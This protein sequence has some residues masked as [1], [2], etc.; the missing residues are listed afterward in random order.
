[1]MGLS[2]KTIHS[3][4][5]Y[6]LIS[7]LL[8]TIVIGCG[9]QTNNQSSTKMKLDTKYVQNNKDLLD[10]RT[11]ESMYFTSA[12]SGWINTRSN[13]QWELFHT[14][15]AGSSWIKYG[16]LHVKYMK[17]I[18]SEG[19]MLS[20]TSIYTTTDNWNHTTKWKLPATVDRSSD[21]SFINNHTGWFISS[22]PDKGDIHQ[23]HQYRIY[24]TNDGGQRFHSS[25]LATKCPVTGIT[26]TENKG[27]LTGLCNMSG[28]MLFKVT[29]DG[30]ESWKDQ[31][32]SLSAKDEDLY[33]ETPQFVSNDVGFILLR[34]G[35]TLMTFKTTDGGT[36]WN[37]Q[38]GFKANIPSSWGFTDADFGWITYK[39]NLWT[40]DDG[41]IHWN[42]ETTLPSNEQFKSIHFVNDSKGWASVHDNSAPVDLKLHMQLHGTNL[43]NTNDSGHSWNKLY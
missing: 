27:W 29:N 36:K 10:K 14:N 30:G 20:D 42:L 2:N 18:G 3:G 40:T 13:N 15:D 7:F 43:Y 39:S 37:L 24:Q 4:V 31:Y 1:M 25:L 26:F 41:G 19:V 9:R 34:Q 5:I 6:I 28:H 8:A 16:D 11:M 32:L 35:I 17:M 22:V 38:G 33:V 23:K 21:V 12:Q